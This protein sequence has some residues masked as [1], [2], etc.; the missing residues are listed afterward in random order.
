MY[1][2][3]CPVHLYLKNTE[4]IDLLI[5]DVSLQNSFYIQV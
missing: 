2:Y 5:H 3:M 4:M 1:R